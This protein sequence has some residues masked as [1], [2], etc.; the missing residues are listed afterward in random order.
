M[1]TKIIILFLSVIF[2]SGSVFSQ[3]F[4]IGIK[5][6]ANMGK[7][8]GKSFKEEFKL[9]YQLGAFATIPLSPRLA[10]Q[11]ELLFNQTNADTSDRFSDIYRFN[12]V[13]KIQLKQLLIPLLLN[14]NLNKYLTV[15]AGP[16]FGVILDKDKNLLQNGQ[17]AFKTTNYAAAA[18]LQANLGNFRIYG[19][20]T[21]GLADLD[22]VGN[23]DRWKLRNIQIGVGIAL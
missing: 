9:G 6:G 8:S 23:N 5:G 16:E 13:G 15:Q 3:G 19:R 1:K 22:N 17:D 4:T 2:L 12:Q 7:I 14:I 21:G 18:G 20:F 11:P 10:L